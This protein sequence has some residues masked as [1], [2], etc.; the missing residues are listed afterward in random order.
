MLVAQMLAGYGEIEWELCDCLR[1]AMSEKTRKSIMT[2]FY[3]LKNEGT[4]IDLADAILRPEFEAIELEAQYG[5]ALGAIRWCKSVRNQYAHCNWG[6]HPEG[7]TFRNME[8]QSRKLFKGPSNHRFLTE[9]LLE[10]QEQYFRYTRACFVYLQH[11][12]YPHKGYGC[13]PTTMPPKMHQP[14]KR[15]HP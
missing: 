3:G 7:L 4:R 2:M 10:L 12:L 15:I 8:E 6:T 11:A 13:L 5:E 1:V 14:L 9:E